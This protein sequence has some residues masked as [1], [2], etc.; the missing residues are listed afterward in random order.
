MTT[1]MLLAL[2]ALLP[3]PEVQQVKHRV[4]GL[5]SRDREEDLK[6]AVKKLAEV[7]VVSIDFDNAEV[8]FSYDPAKLFAGSKP[9]DHLERF[10]NL[11]RSASVSTFGAKPLCTTPK[12][13][14]TRIE[15]PIV[16]LDCKG[17]CLSAYESV[18]KIEGVEQ[19]TAS[20]KEGRLTALIDPEKTSR[21]ALED[22]LKKRNV[23]I[24]AP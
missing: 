15:I 16:G 4:T 23:T 9:K 17:C 21:A 19:A 3:A 5:F 22:A 10:D 7:S 6:E 24:K 11:L 13:K 8:V 18:F 1:S 14:L 20:F 12:E 2:I